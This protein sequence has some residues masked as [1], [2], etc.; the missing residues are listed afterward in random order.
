MRK[1]RGFSAPDLEAAVT[2]AAKGNRHC[3]LHNRE[4]DDRGAMRVAELLRGSK[5]ESVDL[6][7]NNSASSLAFFLVF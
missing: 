1:K 4:L 3:D 7:D 2:T 6:A 5:L